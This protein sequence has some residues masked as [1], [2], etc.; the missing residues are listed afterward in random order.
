MVSAD[1][2]NIAIGVASCC[3]RNRVMRP[4]KYT[5]VDE[6]IYLDRYCSLSLFLKYFHSVIVREV[7]ISESYSN[8]TI[9]IK[10]QL[11]IRSL[12][13]YPST[14]DIN[15]LLLQI[16]LTYSYSKSLLLILLSQLCFLAL[17][18]RKWESCKFWIFPRS[19]SGLVQFLSIFI[20]FP[21]L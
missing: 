4:K 13:N 18:S 2:M 1:N 6:Y 8:T 21:T 14:N 17:R 3:E 7:M 19:N 10:Q 16:T 5:D 15:L 20:I 9:Y 12:N 11:E